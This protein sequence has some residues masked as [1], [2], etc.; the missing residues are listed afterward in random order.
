MPSAFSARRIALGACVVSLGAISFVPQFAGLGYEFSIAAGLVL[1]VSVAIATAIDVALRPKAPLDSLVRGLRTGALF[2]CVAI[3]IGFVSGLRGGLCDA[4]GGLV[5][6]ALG[7]GFGALMGGAWGAF[8]G[9]R[10]IGRARPR[11]AATLVAIVGPLGSAALSVWRF[12]DSPM[13]FAYDPFVGFFSGTLY[14]T[15]VDAGTPLLTYRAGSTATLLAALTIGSRVGRRGVRGIRLKRIDGVLALGFALATA[16]ALVTAYGPAL[17]HWETKDTIAR[18]LGGALTGSRCDVVFPRT[19]RADEAQ[20][21]VRDCDEEIASAER[22]LGARGPERI[23]AF[24]FRDAAEK[25]RLMGAGDTYIAKPWRKEVYLQM[26]SYPHP[27]LGHEIAHVVA[28]A[29]GRGP[30]RIAGAA[31]GYWPNPGLIEG[32]AV[33]TSPDEDELTDLEWAAAMKRKDKLP[34]MRQIFSVDFLGASAAKSYTLAGAFVRWLLDTRGNEVVRR[35]YAG[36]PL[37]SVLGESWEA[38]DARFRAALD[39][40]ALPEAALAYVDSKFERPS[41][42]KRTCPHVVDAER[43]LADQ[44]RDAHDVEGAREHYGNAL[45][46]DP[47]DY[48][49]TLS[50]ATMLVREPGPDAQREGASMLGALTAGDAP[51]GYRHRARE[52]L[53]DLAQNTGDP[54]AAA[55][56]YA[57]LAGQ[58][59]DEDVA[60]TLEVKALAARDADGRAAVRALLIGENGR[61]ADLALASARLGAWEARTGAPLAAYLLGKTTMQ[62]GDFTN[63][64]APLD[65]ALE[66]RASLS[67]RV[68]RE[69]IRQRAVAACASGDRDAASRMKALVSD[70]SGP[71]GASAGGRRESVSRMLERCVAQ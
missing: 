64:A 41:L 24:F 39:A 57:E 43:R 30:F 44:A 23:T 53:A 59:P 14:D 12:Y 50:L 11:L 4:W 10:A 63:A 45:A 16:S 65:R 8:A 37:E 6:F 2:A 25:R 47:H 31:G 51:L 20:L 5:G 49:S 19:L 29:F 69:A 58:T 27:V 3:V 66:R 52:A 71:F 46:C 62:R 1:P 18:E 15:V 67:D 7:P 34:P 35:W 48:A 54:T 17:G 32:V 56:T 13:V 21:L 36:E 70:A 33:A 42:W 61:P 55:A 68:A 38:T 22:V 9:E 28:G 40:I 26:A 60:R